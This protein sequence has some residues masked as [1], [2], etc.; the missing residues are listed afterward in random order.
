MRAENCRIAKLRGN[1][2]E[3][4]RVVQIGLHGD[5]CCQTGCLQE[6]QA[7]R[8]GCKIRPSDEDLRGWEWTINGQM[9]SWSY[10]TGSWSFGVILYRLLLKFSRPLASIFSP[11]LSR[12]T[13]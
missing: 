10:G 1:R 9:V 4:N 7:G 12:L 11:P 13:F 8:K 2:A 5:G 3:V 6:S